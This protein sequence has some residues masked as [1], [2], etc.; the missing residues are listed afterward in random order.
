[1]LISSTPASF[2]FANRGKQSLSLNTKSQKVYSLGK[3]L[4]KADVFIQNM[5]P[6]VMERMGLGY[7]E[8]SKLNQ[9]LF[10]Y[11][12]QAWGRQVHIQNKWYMIL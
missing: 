1:M 7:E 10:M 6:G 9:N 3:L 5:R 12:F 2:A 11:L 4:M 8:I